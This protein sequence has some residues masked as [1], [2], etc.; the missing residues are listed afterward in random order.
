MEYKDLGEPS[1]DIV[2]DIHRVRK[3][4]GQERH[5]IAFSLYESITSRIQSNPNLLEHEEAKQ[6]IFKN[7]YEFK[8]L[9]EFSKIFQKAKRNATEDQDWIQCHEHQNVISSYRR[10]KDGSLSLKIHGEIN[11]LPLFE[12]VSIMRELDLYHHWSPFMNK[13]RKLA[14]LGK[15]DQI[16]WYEVGAM[17]V[18]RD[19]CYRAIGCDCMMETGELVVV[20]MGL[21]DHDDDD[22][23]EQVECLESFPSNASRNKR[24]DDVNSCH[25][26]CNDDDVLLSS[27]TC[28]DNFLA[29]DAMLDTIQL[30]PRPKGFNKDRLHLRFFE[31][32]IKVLS[33]TCVATNIVAN[34]DLKMNIIPDFIIEFIMKHMCGLL[35]VKMQ[36][37]AMKALE[38]PQKSPHATRMREDSFY[39]YWLL[40]KFQS[41]CRK[42]GWDMPSVMALEGYDFEE[43]DD[44]VTSETIMSSPETTA[45][46]GR[47]ESQRKIA[48]LRHRFQKKF[49][50]ERS[51]Q[52]APIMMRE[53]SKK[54]K[55]SFTQF[56]KRRLEE[57]HQLKRIMGKEPTALQEMKFS[58]TKAL[59]TR[60]ETGI[61]PHVLNDYSHLTVLPTIFL[62]QFTVYHGFDHKSLFIDDYTIIRQIITTIVVLC[63]FASLHWATI[64]T[65]LVSTFD[66]IDLPVP[67]F[68]G[69]NESS[70]TRQYFIERIRLSTVVFSI[71]LLMA[72]IGKELTSIF[73]N[74]TSLVIQYAV[75]LVPFVDSFEVQ[76]QTTMDEPIYCQMIDNVK[77]MMTYSSVFAAV[78]C[79]MAV[80]KYPSRAGKPIQITH[81][82]NTSRDH[83]NL[84]R[85]AHSSRFSINLDS[86]PETEKDT[87]Y[88]VDSPVYHSE[89]SSPL[90]VDGMSN[91]PV[92]ETAASI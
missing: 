21:D 44:A 39:R 55:F 66:T 67:K 22:E 38:N 83:H 37:A 60:G 72:G 3:L 4:I 36:G 43:T 34:M 71:G 31:A 28:D 26:R 64:E 70:S 19:S 16:G 23:E 12:Q 15:L 75:A 56:Q 61:I 88:P 85:H 27:K 78:C 24:R 79:A 40:P 82:A 45:E 6:L 77:M 10:E 1:H 41:F 59:K 92:L 48:R 73:L 20:A 5:L 35:L 2:Q 13:S 86:I 32:V 84:Q 52:S 58:V 9:K 54:P 65:V 57:L 68:T 46:D 18:M 47:S 80:A 29:R 69:F 49:F 7:E 90:S 76:K 8:K 87:R 53:T 14:V 89:V 33:P 74:R 42:K 91:I 63:T 11:G 50:S 62:F 25:G 17:G 51:V 81:A 30:P